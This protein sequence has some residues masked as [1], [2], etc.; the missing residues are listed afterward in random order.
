MKQSLDTR[1]IAAALAAL[2]VVVAWLICF[3]FCLYAMNPSQSHNIESLGQFGDVFGSAN[4]LF[5]GLALVGL[6]YTVWL[7]REQNVEVR[8]QTEELK[9]QVASQEVEALGNTWAR[10]SQ[11]CEQFLTA[12]L[13]ATLALLQACEAEAS[14]AIGSR[15]FPRH[16]QDTLRE[17]MRLQQELAILRCEA[18]LGF[19]KGPWSQERELEAIRLYLVN[20]FQEM[21]NRFVLTT[22]QPP[23]IVEAAYNRARFVRDAVALLRDQIRGR[24]V[25]LGG[26]LSMIASDLPEFR[27][28]ATPVENLRG[29]QDWINNHLG[30]SL[31]ESNFKWRGAR[32][33]PST[34]ST[35]RL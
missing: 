20:L 6:V 12:R 29:V 5:T 23:N 31:H 28:K 16:S 19:D 34:S 17:I 8:K 9:K 27:E 2:V 11:S 1:L 14:A 26:T 10:K 21:Q 32:P 30:A 25:E 24:Y 3:G 13:N 4:A 35:T 33:E 22:S 18:Q 15:W 7:Q